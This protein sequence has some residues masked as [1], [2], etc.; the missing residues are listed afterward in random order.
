MSFHW[1]Y[2]QKTKDYYGNN[3][4]KLDFW[5]NKHDIKT[6]FVFFKA[7]L[8]EKEIREILIGLLLAQ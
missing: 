8:E 6:H 2:F 1:N 3:T 4:W 5:D 7:F